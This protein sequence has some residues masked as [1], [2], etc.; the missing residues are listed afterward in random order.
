[1]TLLMIVTE[2]EI[3]TIMNVHPRTVQIF[4][5]A[6]DEAKSCE[7]KDGCVTDQQ[8]KIVFRCV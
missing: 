4:L 7:K 8:K 3:K 1:M 6:Q 2:A 5:H